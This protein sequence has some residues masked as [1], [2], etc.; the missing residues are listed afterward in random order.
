M[1]KISWYFHKVFDKQVEVKDELITWLT[2]ANA[3]M[4]H[5]GN[6][7]CFEYA[8][9][10]L[11]TDDPVIEIG[12]FCGLS[13]NVT[14]H[15][16]KKYNRKN[17]IIT[18]DKWEMENAD[19]EYI[20]NSK[21]RFSDYCDFVK[22]SFKRNVKFFNESN[23][24]YAIEVY[25]DDFFSLWEKKKEVS[26]VFGRTIQ[27]GGGICF[28]YI[29]GNHT[30]EFAKRDFLNTDKYLVKGGFIFFDD[31]NFESP[32]S[33]AKLMKEIKRNPS[34]ELVMKNPNYLFRKKQ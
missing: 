6:V 1:R 19:T 25:S 21:I 17:K 14:G 2:Y 32:Y 26:D 13:A 24:P 8:M 4:M 12:S 29:D 3:G 18:S 31:T 34:Y 22:E 11:P 30:Y 10:N 7:H 27:L 33:C 15:F 20:G 9:K 28:A 23:I 16:L 5:S